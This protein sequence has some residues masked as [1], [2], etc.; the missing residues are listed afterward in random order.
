CRRSKVSIRPPRRRSVARADTSAGST[1]FP[2]AKK[3]T[4]SSGG[5]PRSWSSTSA[6]KAPS[7]K[8]RPPCGPLRGSSSSPVAAARSPSAGVPGWSARQTSA[9]ATTATTRRA[10][11]TIARAIR[12]AS[13]LSGC[14]RAR[15]VALERLS[16]QAF[17]RSERAMVVAQ[18][19]DVLY[20]RA[21]QRA[22]RIEDLEVAEPARAIPGVQ[23]R[24]SL[25][26]PGNHVGP[27]RRDLLSGSGDALVGVAQRGA[28]SDP[29]SVRVL[30][31]LREAALRGGD[32]AL[33]PVEDR[34]RDRKPDDERIHARVEE[35]A[36]AAA[37]RDVRHRPRF[38]EIDRR[39]ALEKLRRPAAEVRA[40]VEPRRHA[41]EARKR[42]NSF[43]VAARAPEASFGAS[44]GRREL[45]A[46]DVE[47]TPHSVSLHPGRCSRHLGFGELRSRRA[48]GANPRRHGVDDVLREL[49]VL[50]GEVELLLCDQDR[51]E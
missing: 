51:D 4:R 47:R 6:A 42:R 3:Y 36:I 19:A 23:R 10:E 30:S 43:E 46:G 32:R 37:R 7:S 31:R 9:P 17:D 11:S 21:D 50:L 16:E 48:A 1:G 26:R 41:C 14:R 15:I 18:R 49:H 5:R 22:L 12:M 24:E 38:F 27:K 35:A 2:S 8:S 33:V 20:A 28:E 45:S 34:E 40:P 44:P 13:L 39:A 29:S 25:A